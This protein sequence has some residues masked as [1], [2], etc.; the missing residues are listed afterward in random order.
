MLQSLGLAR[1]LKNTFVMDQIGHK[2]M[3]KTD[4]ISPEKKRKRIFLAIL[5]F[6]F[7]GLA[8]FTH[9]GLQENASF[10]VVLDAGHGGSDPGN[11]GTGRYKTTEKNI[12]L[13]V[14]LQVGKYIQEHFPNVKV[15][16]TRTGDTFPT[17]KERCNMANNADAD[18]FIS[19]HCNANSKEAPNGVE[20]FV[21]GL[22]KSQESLE[23]AMRENNSIFL[24]KD[25]ASDYSGFDPKNPDTYIILSMRENAFMEKSIDIAKN[26]QDQF[27]TRVGRK[28][29]GV[30]QAGFYV[31]SYTN[32]PSILVEL[33]FLTNH[34]EEDFLQSTDGKT[35]TASAIYRAFKDFMAKN[36]P[37]QKPVQTQNEPEIKFTPPK[38]SAPTVSAP[39]KE[40]AVKIQKTD[41]P[42]TSTTAT[43]GVRYHIQ[44]L[45]SATPLKKG[46]PQFKGLTNS[47]EYKQNGVYK[48]LTGTTTNYK[49]AKQLQEQMRDRGFKDAFIVAFENDK[50][51]DLSKAIAQ[52]TNIKNE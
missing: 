2:T 14:T 44:I 31:I 35:Y 45:S 52:T 23:S 28:D 27:R 13:D 47:T 46:D 51:I 20:T 18:L 9:R 19:I 50:R 25:H 4:I 21:M 32:M 10:I 48:Y 17:L 49:E 5:V 7:L 1:D 12:S 42:S 30:K 33:G 29:R 3:Q 43:S 24:E 15:V 38:P 34:D 16:Y 26:V 22:H 40:D 8:A 37:D 11:L 39:P 36:K 6:T 41:T